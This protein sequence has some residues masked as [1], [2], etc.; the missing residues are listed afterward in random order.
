MDRRQVVL[1]DHMLGVLLAEAFR[2][3]RRRLSIQLAGCGQVA[4]GLLGERHVVQGVGISR[5]LL[6][7]DAAANRQGPARLLLG[8]QQAA[9]PLCRDRQVVQNRGGLGAFAAV[10]GFADGLGPPQQ[11]FALREATAAD[12]QQAQI[13][14]VADEVRMLGP[15]RPLERRQRLPEQPLG[16]R[17]VAQFVVQG[18]QIAPHALVAAWSGPCTWVLMATARAKWVSARA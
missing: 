6:A 3:D 4:L 5:V 17:P 18:G 1:H 16:L 8:F 14:Q 12:E 10:R 15:E 7:D 2:Q 9:H 11:G 13:V